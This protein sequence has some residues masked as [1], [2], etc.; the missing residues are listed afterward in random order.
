MEFD[1]LPDGMA[2]W[3]RVGEGDPDGRGACLPKSVPGCQSMGCS[4]CG[5]AAY[6]QDELDQFLSLDGKD[7]FVIYLAPVGKVGREQ[8]E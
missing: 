8:E 6:E 1:P 3:Y 5:V 2:L 7:E 4:T